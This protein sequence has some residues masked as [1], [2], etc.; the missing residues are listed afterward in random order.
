MVGQ[1]ST[2]FP[3]WTTEEEPFGK[4]IVTDVSVTGQKA[5]TLKAYCK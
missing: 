5:T 2:D 1:T 3:V 4:T